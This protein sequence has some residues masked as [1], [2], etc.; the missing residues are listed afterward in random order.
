MRYLHL[1]SGNMPQGVSGAT[2]KNQLTKKRERRMI[3]V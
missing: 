2:R 1:P 3:E